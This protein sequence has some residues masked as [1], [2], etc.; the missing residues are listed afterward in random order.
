MPKISE[1][2]HPFFM[3][4]TAAQG[5]QIKRVGMQS[6]IKNR[7]FKLQIVLQ[8]CHRR[9]SINQRLDRGLSG[10]CV[11]MEN[12]ITRCTRQLG[13][14]LDFQRS[15]SKKDPYSGGVRGEERFIIP[16]GIGPSGN[17]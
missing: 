17:E 1:T 15:A 3:G 2:L 4:P 14:Y 8:K 7:Y 9:I 10:R 6:R 11:I 16:A 5:A 13:G 12:F